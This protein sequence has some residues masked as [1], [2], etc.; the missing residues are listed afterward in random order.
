MNDVFC[1]YMLVYVYVCVLHQECLRYLKCSSLYM[2]SNHSTRNLVLLITCRY[3]V[4]TYVHAYICMQQLYV[5][6]MCICMYIMCRYVCMSTCTKRGLWGCCQ[7]H[8]STPNWQLSFGN[9]FKPRQ[10]L[11]DYP[12]Q[13]IFILA[14][15]WQRFYWWQ[16]SKGSPSSNWM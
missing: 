15:K 14:P 11:H 6:C 3:H 2:S 4:C 1:V 9:I 5:C 8:Y 13:Q 16:Q 7:I 12:W 10:L